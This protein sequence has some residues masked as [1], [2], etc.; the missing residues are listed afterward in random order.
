MIIQNYQSLALV[1]SQALG[2]GS[3]ST[4]K[5]G[6]VMTPSN[7]EQAKAMFNELMSNAHR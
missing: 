2:G 7:A 1:V 4:K 5:A 3:S 6:N